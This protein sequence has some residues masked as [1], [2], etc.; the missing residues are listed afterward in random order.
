[1]AR[2]GAGGLA[3][4]RPRDAAVIWSRKSTQGNWHNDSFSTPRSKSWFPPQKW[5]VVGS[6]PLHSWC[7]GSTLGSMVFCVKVFVCGFCLRKVLGEAMLCHPWSSGW[8]RW[9][10]R[11]PSAPAK[12]NSSLDFDFK[13]DF[14]LYSLHDYLWIV[15]LKRLSSLLGCWHEALFHGENWGWWQ[16]MLLE[17]PRSCPTCTLLVCLLSIFHK[18]LPRQWSGSACG[19]FCR[20]GWNVSPAKHIRVA[21]ASR[22]CQRLY[23]LPVPNGSSSW[24]GNSFLSNFYFVPG[25]VG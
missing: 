18:V 25:R 21:G 16:A 6:L 23:L 3:W 10:A 9:D 22:S 15:V 17:R 14:R 20:H 1:M 24:V 13:E 5:V 8:M 19:S 4:Q 2:I 7:V 12:P 11:N